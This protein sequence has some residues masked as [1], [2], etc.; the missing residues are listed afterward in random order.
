MHTDIHKFQVSI[1]FDGFISSSVRNP[2][3]D[4]WTFSWIRLFCFG[5]CFLFSISFFLF[6]LS[7]KKTFSLKVWMMNLIILRF[8]TSFR[9][10]YRIDFVHLPHEFSFVKPRFTCVCWDNLS[11]IFAICL[12]FSGT[13]E[14]HYNHARSPG[15]LISFI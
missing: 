3:R 13:L 11:T 8:F 1:I 10:T 15:I 7:F 2:D 12:I 9:A 14:A 5:F 4:G 6:C